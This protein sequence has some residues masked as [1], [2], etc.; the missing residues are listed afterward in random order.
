MKNIDSVTNPQ[1]R[2][3]IQSRFFDWIFLFLAGVIFI[4]TPLLFLE[5]K[6]DQW[7][8][9]FIPIRMV[10]AELK[11]CLFITLSSILIGITWIRINLKGKINYPVKPVFFFGCLFLLSIVI[12]NLGAYNL[13]RAW[14]SSFTWHLLPIFLVFSL[15]QF[16]WSH[17]RFKGFISLIL[18]G[19]A[20]SCLVALDQHYLWTDWSHRLPRHTK[21][22]PAGIIFNHNFAAEFHAPI[23]PMA[24]GLCFYVKTN[25]TRM[26]ILA[27]IIVIFM[28][29]LSLSLARGAWIGL[30][31]GCFLTGIIFITSIFIKPQDFGRKEKKHSLWL[32]SS[33]IFLALSLPLYL[34]TSDYW[35]KGTIAKD[36]L[37]KEK[38][39]SREASE[40][41]SIITTSELSSGSARRIVLW[42]DALQAIVSK[43]FLFGKGTDHYELHFHESAKLSDKT[44]G[45]TLVRFVHNDFIQILYENGIIG[46]VGFIGLWI[47]ILWKALC[48]GMECVKYNDFNRL[49]LILG[50]TASCLTFLIE[51]FFE[52]PTRSPCAMV[53]GWTSLGLLLVVTSLKDL[54]LPPKALTPINPKINLLIGAAAV[55]IIPFGCLLAKDL[56]WSNVYHFQGRIAGDYGEK[57]KSL[58]FH[59]NSIS[60]TPWQHHSRKFESYYLLTHKK[61]FP[62]AL[63][64]INQTLKVHPGCLVAHQNKIKLSIQ[65][66]KDNQM[67]REALK[68]MKKAAPFH[69]YTQRESKRVANLKP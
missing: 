12:S 38:Q 56:F 4:V 10:N 68:A 30:I 21:S 39:V 22:I 15:L 19:G 23:I 65:E 60:L 50:L 40:L 27:S 57:N 6:Q 42:K 44:T 49:A 14:V 11:L 63:E 13:Q 36:S 34:T 24:L 16:N 33:F 28:P 18:L 46:L 35:K 3:S 53:V 29:A 61:Q 8:D 54:D 66:F 64:S 25:F 37:T 26:L 45:S 32:A 69:T 41:K 2:N 20:F 5:L 48:K 51:S 43:D 58:I 1:L 67:A 17:S 7:V 31:A 59:R 52:F 62:E 55:W 9:G 47:V